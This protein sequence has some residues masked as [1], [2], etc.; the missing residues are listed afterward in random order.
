MPTLADKPDANTYP[1]I[2]AWRQAEVRSR[3]RCLANEPGCMPMPRHCPDRSCRAPAPRHLTI[4]PPCDD[5]HWFVPLSLFI[6]PAC[7]ARV[8]DIMSFSRNQNVPLNWGN[9]MFFAMKLVVVK[10]VWS[11]LTPAGKSRIGPLLKHYFQLV[12]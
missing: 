12:H 11:C 7:S 5:W 8:N 3:F 6:P 2:L 1:T 10:I 9:G 4:C